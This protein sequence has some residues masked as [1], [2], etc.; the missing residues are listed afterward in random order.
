MIDEIF[1]NVAEGQIQL[2]YMATES[3]KILIS[4]AAN[5]SKTLLNYK[6][7]DIVVNIGSIVYVPDKFT[8]KTVNR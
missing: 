8:R 3:K 6:P 7:I 4:L 2:K 1:P 5:L